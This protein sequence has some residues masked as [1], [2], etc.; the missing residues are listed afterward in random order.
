MK[1]GKLRSTLRYALPALI[2]MGFVVGWGEFLFKPI[3]FHANQGSLTFG[4]VAAD[5]LKVVPDAFGWPFAGYVFLLSTII[6][7]YVVLVVAL[8]PMRA[9]WDYIDAA[10]APIS[11]IETDIRLE[12]KQNRA[13]ADIVRD[14]YFHAN[15]PGIMAYHHRATA[16]HGTTKISK[17]ETRLNS[18]VITKPSPLTQK[19]GQQFDLIEEFLEPLPTSLLLTY[20][21]KNWVLKLHKNTNRCRKHVLQRTCVIEERGE[22]GGEHPTFGITVN[23]YPVSNLRVVLD[24]S[25]GECP[26]SKTVKA[27]VVEERAVRYLPVVPIRHDGRDCL[28]EAKCDKLSSGEVFR[29][30][31]RN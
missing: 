12:F 14:Q 5:L 20:L 26:E 28:Y 15:V 21:P 18:E 11:V 1:R 13:D 31:W 30:Q 8:R 23:R 9:A 2:A 17:L 6:L 10:E 29:I 16:F 3:I 25:K 27:Y 24:F 4:T 7:T 22:Y 19:L